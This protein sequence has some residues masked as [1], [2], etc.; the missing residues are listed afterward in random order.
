MDFE[1]GVVQAVRELA[2]DGDLDSQDVGAGGHEAGRLVERPGQLG[3]GHRHADPRTRRVAQQAG[4]LLS[5]DPVAVDPVERLARQPPCL[6][7]GHGAPVRLEEELRLEGQ[8]D[9]PAGDVEREMLRVEVVLEQ[10]H[11]EGQRDPRAQALARPAHP[12]VHDGAGQLAGRR[13]RGRRPRTGAGPPAPGRA[14]SRRGRS[15][16]ACR[17]AT[18]PGRGARRAVPGP[19]SSEPPGR[20]EEARACAPR[21]GRRRRSHPGPG[22]SRRGTANPRPPPR[23]PRRPRRRTGRGTRR[24]RPRTVRS[25]RPVARGIR[26]PVENARKMSPD[27]CPALEPARARPRPARRAM[28]SS[29]AGRSGASVA[30]TTTQLPRSRSVDSSARPSA[31]S[32]WPTR[33]PSMVRRGSRPKLVSASTPTVYEGVMGGRPLSSVRRS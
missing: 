20:C 8:V 1:P 27:P 23:W 18:S 19:T 14:R 11:R 9:R 22:P 33:T 26:R 10:A 31:I 28:R 7:L 32:A 5:R 29:A 2:S 21:G 15:H 4:Q 13:G 25:G 3:L 17:R 12:A 6:G 16:R 24:R 30:T